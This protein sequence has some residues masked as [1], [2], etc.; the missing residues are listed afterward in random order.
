MINV[1]ILGITNGMAGTLSFGL[2]AR[3]SEDE[4]KGQAGGSISFFTILGIFLGS[5]FSFAVGAIL[6]AIK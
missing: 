4:I 5:C 3:L 2:A 6:D 1:A